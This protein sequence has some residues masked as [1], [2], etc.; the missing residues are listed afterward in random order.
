MIKKTLF[1][2]F[3]IFIAYTLVMPFA[4]P[5][6]GMNGFHIGFMPKM[7]E[8]QNSMGLMHFEEMIDFLLS[9][10]IVNFII[11]IVMIFTVV[12]STLFLKIKLSKLP[13]LKNS[14]SRTAIGKAKPFDSLLLAYKK[15]IIQNITFC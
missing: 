10:N 2:I 1:I 14:F 11:L 15:G 5:N 6:C 12:I 3:L 9:G 8:C 13:I 7:N 4:I